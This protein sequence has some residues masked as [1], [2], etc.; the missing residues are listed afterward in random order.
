MS[1]PYAI[2][3]QINSILKDRRDWVSGKK[4]ATLNRETFH[5]KMEEVYAYLHTASASL[6]NKAVS[7]EM[8]NPKAQAQIRHML[9]MLKKVHDGKITQEKADH[10]FGLEMHNKFVRPITDKLEPPADK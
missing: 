7:G 10:V 3:I 6:F 4:Y 9:D 5:K 8:D 1:D 2:E